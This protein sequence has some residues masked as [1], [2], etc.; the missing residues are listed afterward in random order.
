MLYSLLTLYCNINYIF[1]QGLI[2]K[3]RICTFDLKIRHNDKAL[4]DVFSKI[5]KELLFLYNFLHN[6]LQHKREKP[7]S[8]LFSNIMRFTL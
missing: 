6:Y 3:K 4:S 1:L 8:L 2:V 7:I 5:S